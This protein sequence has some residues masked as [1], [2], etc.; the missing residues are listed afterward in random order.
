MISNQPP[1][2]LLLTKLSPPPPLLLTGCGGARPA[3]IYKELLLLARLVSEGENVSRRESLQ[4]MR[5]GAW[6]V[7][8]VCVCVCV[9]VRSGENM[10]ERLREGASKR[11]RGGQRLGRTR[12]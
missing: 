6:G 11:E 5:V 7:A 8:R 12:P 1:P 3:F 4:S 9:F 10:R 2:P